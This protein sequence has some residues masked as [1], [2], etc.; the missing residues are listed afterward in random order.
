MAT[1]ST[2]APVK[3]F[4]TG[5]IV[6][7]AVVG[8]LGGFLFGYDSAVINGANAAIQYNFSVSDQALGVVV[9]IALVGC[10]IGAWFAGR[11]ADHFGRKRVALTAAVLFL[12][13]GIGQGLPFGAADFMAWRLLGGFAIGVAS[14]AAPMY[15]SEISPTHLRGRLT[16]LFQFAIVIG[17]FAT[18][19]GNYLL[20]QAAGTPGVCKS[21]PT[22]QGECAKNSAGVLLAPESTGALWGLQAWQW[23]FLLMA[24]PAVL[25]FV[26]TLLVPESPR[27][28]V[29][30]G[31][32]EQARV[33]IGELMGGD[34]DAKLAEIQA[35]VSSDHPPRM[36]DLR[37]PRFGLMPIVWIAIILNLFQQ[38]V[39]INAVIYYSNLVYAAVGL[40]E[41]S[42][43]LTSMI[44]TGVN[45]LFTIVAIVMIDRIGRKKLLLIGSVGMAVSLAVI[46]VIFGTASKCAQ[47]TAGTDG[48]DVAADIGKPL[49]AHGPGM[50]AVIAVN[51]FIAFFAATWGPVVWVLIAEMFPNRIRAAGLAVGAMA[52]W[53]GNLIVSSA[54]PAMASLSIAL[55]YAIFTVFAILSFWFVT[56]KVRETK[57]IS[58]EDMGELEKAELA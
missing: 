4:S 21:D 33:V 22:V 41:S 13:A 57:G 58:L 31:K 20:L 32:T 27:Y 3:V 5:R 52:Q 17:I 15:I 24:I 53:I 47:L 40:G 55:T 10:A 30:A 38:F 35:T 1:G 19:L 39:G 26:L 37:G 56:K 28:L 42:A 36:S 6:F 23:M 54:F 18:G 46:A 9:S 34:A 7:L 2:S 45:F 12:V 14:V 44:T 11:L 48:C 29:Q 25:Y 50:V 8:A 51:V 16:A 43:F 49:I